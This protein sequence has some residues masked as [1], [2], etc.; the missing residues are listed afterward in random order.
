MKLEPIT[1]IITKKATSSGQ[2][3]CSHD[4]EFKLLKCKNTEDFFKYYFRLFIHDI[5]Y[6]FKLTKV[7]NNIRY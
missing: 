2:S 4:Y 6:V 7:Q 1:T 5:L 3:Y